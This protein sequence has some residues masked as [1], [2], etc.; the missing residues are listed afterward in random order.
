VRI[1]K[2]WA[3]TQEQFDFDSLGIQATVSARGRE[4][5]Q[6]IGGDTPDGSTPPESSLRCR[7]QF[8]FPEA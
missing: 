4:W 2:H 7:P 3:T 5:L 1:T 6:L 8:H